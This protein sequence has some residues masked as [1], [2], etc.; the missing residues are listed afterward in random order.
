MSR[1]AL[2]LLSV[3]GLMMLGSQQVHSRAVQTD[4]EPN[5]NL[6][7]VDDTRLLETNFGDRISPDGDENLLNG[8]N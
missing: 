6:M 8:K 1:V 3:A 2:L 5:D 7:P 4:A